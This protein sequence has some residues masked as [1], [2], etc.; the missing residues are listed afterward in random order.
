[1]NKRNSLLALCCLLWIVSGCFEKQ[2]R[3]VIGAGEPEF[4]VKGRILD[5]DNDRPVKDAIVRIESLGLID[6][7]NAQGEYE[8]T[9]IPVGHRIIKV[10]AP[11]YLYKTSEIEFEY[12]EYDL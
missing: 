7:V 2:D 11:D 9:G 5:T 12:D 3:N 8:L 10:T 4:T 6:T 1:M